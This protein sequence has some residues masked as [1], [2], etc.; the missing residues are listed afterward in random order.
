MA[1]SE[2]KILHDAWEAETQAITAAWEA[3]CPP[4]SIALKPAESEALDGMVGA[5]REHGEDAGGVRARD[6]LW[7]FPGASSEQ[8]IVWRHPSGVLIRVLID[9]LVPYEDG[10]GRPCW[11]VADLKSTDDPSPDAFR[12]SVV[13]YGYHRQGAVSYTHLTLPTKRIV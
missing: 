2:W 5:L 9:R 4:D 6:L 1:F 10:A 11:F 13:K 7:D 8:A 3:T 12:R